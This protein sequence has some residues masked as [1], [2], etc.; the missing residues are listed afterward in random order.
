VSK[1]SVNKNVIFDLGGV[2]ITLNYQQAIRRFNEV[3]VE[4]ASFYL[5]PYHQNGIFLELEQGLLSVTEFQKAL[6]NE[7][8]K[9]ISV[10]QITYGWLGFVKDVPTK[11]LLLLEKLRQQGYKL[12]LLSNTN[13]FIMSFARSDK[14][15]ALGKSIDCYFDKLFL[16]YQMKCVKPN[17]EIFQKMIADT[18]IKPSET[19]FI[20]DGQKN[21]LTAKNLGFNIYLASNGEDFTD[22]FSELM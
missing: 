10:E 20:D 9:N 6:Q 14:F 12:F 18:Q 13:P 5:D 22:Y 4:N 21:I 8:G 11:K 15:S 2:L 19:L 17:I 1:I 3:G 7:I 16:S